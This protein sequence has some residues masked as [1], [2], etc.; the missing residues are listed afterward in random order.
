M[1]T[2]LSL[3]S[4]RLSS[5]SPV[6]TWN[7]VSRRNQSPRGMSAVLYRTTLSWGP[8]ANLASILLPRVGTTFISQLQVQKGVI[9]TYP[10]VCFI[11]GCTIQE[12]RKSPCRVAEQG[13]P[14]VLQGF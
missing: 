2:S 7:L 8:S 6:P 1:A 4:C 12:A 13:Q 11:W 3:W 14:T 9:C 10:G 5:P